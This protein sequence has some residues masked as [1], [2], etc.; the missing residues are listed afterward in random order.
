MKQKIIEQFNKI[1][2]IE[3][4]SS[5]TIKCYSSVFKLFLEYMNKFR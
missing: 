3:N 5:Q 1:Q 4:Y 2:E